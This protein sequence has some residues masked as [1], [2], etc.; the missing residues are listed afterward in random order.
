MIVSGL[1]ARMASV[2][3]ITLT[4]S[5]ESGPYVSLFPPKSWEDSDP[6]DPSNSAIKVNLLQPV[7]KALLTSV[8]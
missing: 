7:C 1:K 3:L 2:A 4:K 6:K 5:Q 8:I